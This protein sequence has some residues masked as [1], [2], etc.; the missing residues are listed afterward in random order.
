MN[1]CI[2]FKYKVKITT[3]HCY[4]SEENETIYDNIWV[5]DKN[6]IEKELDGGKLIDLIVQNLKESYLSE[7]KIV[8][9]ELHFE[10]FNYNNGESS[11]KC[12]CIEEMRLEDER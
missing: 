11:S 3:K 9:N 6:S 1:I 10:Y 2:Y 12:Y 4:L 5:H 7:F 8:G